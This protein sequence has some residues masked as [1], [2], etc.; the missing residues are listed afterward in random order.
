MIVLISLGPIGKD[1]PVY[2]KNRGKIAIDFGAT[3]D[4]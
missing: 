4:A 2:L 1:L 3:I